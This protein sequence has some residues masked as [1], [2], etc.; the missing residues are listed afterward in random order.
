M[1]EFECL[2]GAAACNLKL[3]E[4]ADALRDCDIAHE[5]DPSSVKV[6]YRRSQVPPPPPPR[7][8]PPP[9]PP[10]P[11]QARC[12]RQAVGM[13]RLARLQAKEALG[14][15]AGALADAN[16]I[17]RIEPKNKEAVDAARRISSALKAQQR[18]QAEGT[19]EHFERVMAAVKVILWCSTM[20]HATCSAQ[21]SF[22][23]QRI[24]QGTVSAPMRANANAVRRTD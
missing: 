17:L 2:S 16:L 18:E 22:N 10:P 4:F 7:P 13:R 23:I 24:A 12:S 20:Q 19:Y 9:P 21:L 6:L 1:R 15:L 5:L 14:Q 8:P 3:K 11:P